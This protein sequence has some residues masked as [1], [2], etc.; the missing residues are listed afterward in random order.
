[1][2]STEHN[3]YSSFRESLLE[4]LFSGEVMKYLWL[5]GVHRIELLKPQVDDGGYDLVFEANG[6]TRHVQLK[7]SRRGS[8]TRQVNINLGLAGRRSGC[9]IWM[10]FDPETLALGPYY[11]F[12]GDPDAGLPDVSVFR[13]AKHTKANSQGIKAERPNLRAVP[14]T[15]FR[16]V[17]DIGTLVSLLFGFD[18]EG[19]A[20]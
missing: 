20:D 13:S 1:M 17:D 4:H 9:V 10:E 19:S 2:T 5:R 11:W 16:R 14:R 8:A 7:A 6:I 3:L 12:G 18:F 15:S